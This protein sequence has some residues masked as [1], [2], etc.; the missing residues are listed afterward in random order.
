[1]KKI[2]IKFVDYWK[3]HH[4]EEDILYRWLCTHYDVELSDN[5]DYIIYSCF[6]YEHLKY[7]CIRIFY[8]GENVAP[9]FNECDYAISFEKIEFE[10][11]HIC[12]PNF[13]KYKREISMIA[14]RT[15]K[16]KEDV[17]QRKFCCFVVSNGN[18]DSIRQEAF[19]KLNE[20]KKVD[21]GGRFMNNIGGPVEDKLGFQ[22]NYKFALAFENSAHKGYTTEKILQAFASGVV[23]IYWGDP[24]VCDYFN[25]EA[26][27]NIGDF[28]SLDEAIEYIRFVDSNDNNYLSML[29]SNVWSKDYIYE[30]KMKELD[31]FLKN[32]FEQDY[33]SA[34]RRNN[35]NLS[36]QYEKNI[37]EWTSVKNSRKSILGRL[38]N[39]KR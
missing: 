27:I 13:F 9:N 1:M 25:R 4:L 19:E 34:Y 12:M 23:P 5:P 22:A 38:L 20:Y 36:K 26:F 3:N 32:I 14:N 11:R 29:Q 39:I 21:S 2:Y 16:L 24:N 10:D 31:V 35:S 33:Y 30:N 17:L 6:G 7:D 28:T 15:N 37:I 18:A 8:T